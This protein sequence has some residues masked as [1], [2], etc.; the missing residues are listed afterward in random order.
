MPQALTRSTLRVAT[1]NLRALK[2]DT[3][4]A[5]EVIRTISPD[6]LLIQEAPRNP[7][8]TYAITA[9]ARQSGLFWS[10]R[11]RLAAGTTLMTGLKI[12]DGDSV[13]RA[14]KVGLREN[15]RG[16]TLAQVRSPGRP[17]VAVVSIHLSLDADQRMRHTRTILAELSAELPQDQPLVIAGDI[18]EGPEGQAWG[19]LAARLEV[20]SADQPTFPAAEPHRRIDAIFSRGHH[21]VT[22]GDSSIL[23]PTLVAR[24]SDH[25]PVWVDLEF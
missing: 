12:D 15:P 6:V 13:D 22:P 24:A 25:V 20:V 9:L 7:I 3:A 19:E 14:L 23:D 16:Y 5:A 1:Y 4:A 18:N 17:R 2:D 8:S 10:G 21:S 11:T